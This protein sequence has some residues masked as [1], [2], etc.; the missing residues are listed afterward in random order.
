METDRPTAAP[1]V[2]PR[3]RW[4]LRV[5]LAIT[6]L[7]LGLYV[8]VRLDRSVAERLGP[9]GEGVYDLF[10]QVPGK[11]PPLTAASKRLIADVKA[12]GGTAS[13]NVR[14]L[15]YFGSLGQTESASVTFNGPEF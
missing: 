13:V 7:S 3:P 11:P 4:R 8:F 14:R 2:K 9:L 1:T 6:A 15:G 10:N 12:M 5:L